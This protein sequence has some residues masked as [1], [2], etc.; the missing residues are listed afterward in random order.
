MPE[1]SD[2]TNEEE[3]LDRLMFQELMEMKVDVRLPCAHCKGKGTKNSETCPVCDGDKVVTQSMSL[4][5]IGKKL[6]PMFVK[7]LQAA[8]QG[9][10]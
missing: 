4:Y 5:S 3:L 6:L 9:E 2:E 1:L 7:G 8:L 10:R